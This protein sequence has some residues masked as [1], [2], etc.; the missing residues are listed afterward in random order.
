MPAL[1]QQVTIQS[2]FFRGCRGIVTKTP[3][4]VMNMTR[5]EVSSHWRKACEGDGW[6]GGYR[7]PLRDMYHV[8]ITDIGNMSQIP[9]K[10]LKKGQLVTFLQP[11]DIN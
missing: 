10:W 9:P 11:N 7:P 4:N 3:D 6:N 2:G 5:S 8:K 1:N